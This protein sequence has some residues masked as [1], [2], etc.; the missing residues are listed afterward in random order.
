MA[1]AMIK[2]FFIIY[3]PSRVGTKNPL[4]VI[5]GK[6]NNGINVVAMCAKS[7]G[8]TT[9]SKPR[10]IK[11]IPMTH[12]NMPNRTMK[13]SNDIKLIV[14]S[15]RLCTKGLA[16]DTPITFKIPN[17]KKITNK[18]K[19]AIGIDA[20][21]KKLISFISISRS[22]FSFHMLKVYTK[23]LIYQNKYKIKQKNKLIQ[24]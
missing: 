5:A 1:T 19:R 11:R 2:R 21:L 22:E 12:S 18:L 9:R 24:T 23:I 20:R 3:C 6:R 17:Q 10:M 14:L 16:E 15:K 4:Q 8:M 13:V 7:I